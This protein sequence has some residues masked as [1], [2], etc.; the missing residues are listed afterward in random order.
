[1]EFNSALW[2]YSTEV[3]KWWHEELSHLFSFE[4][5]EVAFKMFNITLLSYTRHW[6][7]LLM[8]G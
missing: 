6:F 4:V 8:A 2:E 5:P 3:Q 7:Y 1:M